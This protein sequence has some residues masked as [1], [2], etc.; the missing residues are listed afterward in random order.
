MY[1]KQISQEPAIFE[2]AV[3]FPNISTSATNC[4]VIKDRGE[5]LV[6]DTGAPTKEAG[7]YFLAGLEELDVD[8]ENA[9]YFLTHFHLDHAGLVDRLISKSAPLYVGQVEFDRTRKSKS[10]DL[11]DEL[12]HH[13]KHLGANAQE[14]EACRRLEKFGSEFVS[15]DHNLRFVSDGDTLTIGSLRLE[16]VGTG[17]HTEGH[18]SL[19]EP[20]S[21]FF[22]GGDHL[23]FVISPSIDYFSGN[24]DSL[25]V[26]LDNLSKIKDLPIKAL[27][28]AHGTIRD[29]FNDRADW[30]IR[31]HEKRL[32]ELVAKANS[33]SKLLRIETIKQLA[34]NVPSANW[35]KISVEQRSIIIIQG[36][37]LLNHLEKTGRL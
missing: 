25:S 30:L 14:I 21:G 17:G 1:A 20:R 7:D 6:V 12:A 5:V 16:V 29:D 37:V 18:L 33:N 31:H 22:I 8:R 2:I 32:D 9:S 36:L 15:E 10:A 35:E 24:R 4:Y 34:W 28:P 26:Y 11:V 3:P 13:L 27:L 19:F 23:L